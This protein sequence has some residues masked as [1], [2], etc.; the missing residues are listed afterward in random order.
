MIDPEVPAM[1]DKTNFARAA[2]VAI[3]ASLA[4][5]ST[6]ALAACKTTLRGELVQAPAAPVLRQAYPQKFLFFHL[7]ELTPASPTNS[8]QPFQ[9][10]LVLNTST[11][12]P[13]PFALDID[14]PGIVRANSN[15]ASPLTTALMTQITR[16]SGLPVMTYR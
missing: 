12:L 7:A 11:T 10:F 9:S 8:E 16:S 14:R 6:S 15:C 13:I 2:A 4:V 5:T 1:D 3:A